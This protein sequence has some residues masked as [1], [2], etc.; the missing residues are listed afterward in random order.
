[1]T[2]PSSPRS[3]PTPPMPNSRTGA[4]WTRPPARRWRPTVSRCGSTASSRPA[5]GSAR[6]GPSHWTLETNE[7][8]YLVA[9]R[10]TVTP[11]GGEPAEIGVGDVAVLPEGLDRH[12]GHPRDR[13][14]GLRDLLRSRDHQ[15]VDGHHAVGRRDHRVG[16]D[17]RR[18]HRRVRLPVARIRRSPSASASMS[19]GRCAA[20]AGQQRCDPQRARAAAV[21]PLR[22]DG[23]AGHRAVG[24]A[25][26]PACRRRRP[27]PADRMRHRG[28]TRPRSPR[29][30]RAIAST[31]TSGPRRCRHRP[32]RP[33]AA[34]RRRGGRGPPRR[35]RS[36]ARHQG[37]SGRPGSRSRRGGQRIAEA[38]ARSRDATTGMP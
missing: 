13:P 1:M 3:S 8:I 24:R 18:A 25:V 14:Q 28:R 16:L 11:D 32:R 7:V 23:R 19:T 37:F 15:R 29:P 30:R 4:R 26:P 34:R 31:L 2:I 12:L 33:H 22:C 9:G 17:A 20:P 5:S 6:P 36:C 38:C 21:R 27:R 10:M 35:H